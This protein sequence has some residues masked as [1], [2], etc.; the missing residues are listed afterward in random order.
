MA[1]IERSTVHAVDGWMPAL[2]IPDN[3][4][5]EFEFSATLSLQSDGGS[6]AVDVWAGRGDPLARV[7]CGGTWAALSSA[8]LVSPAWLVEDRRSWC[9]AFIGG[10][11]CVVVGGRGRPK[12]RYISVRRGGAGDFDIAWPVTREQSDSYRAR[13]DQLWQQRGKGREERAESATQS[14]P[15]P[16]SFAHS[17]LQDR[18]GEALT[19]WKER[20]GETGCRY[21]DDS[22]QR[23]D[24]AIEALRRA[25]ADGNVE[26]QPRA[27]RFDGQR[28][29]NV[30]CWPGRGR[31]A[32]VDPAA[33]H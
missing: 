22:Q 19:W 33:L 28:I 8:G 10:E 12:G 16:V 5:M 31:V 9:V 17:Q 32:S 20:V 3:A 18:L 24:L 6:I 23:I 11:P 29:G 4:G 25:V 27:R 13:L 14:G 7:R 1:E 15:W 26:E 21:T 2:A 30:V